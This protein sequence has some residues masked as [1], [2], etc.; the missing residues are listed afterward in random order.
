VKKFLIASSVCG[1][2]GLAP[3]D[4]EFRVVPPVAPAGFRGWC[5]SKSLTFPP[6]MKHEM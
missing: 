5:S 4:V 1:L 2:V 6:V 3:I